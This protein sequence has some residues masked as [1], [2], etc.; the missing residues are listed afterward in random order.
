MNAL[1]RTKHSMPHSRL[2]I[3]NIATAGHGNEP[4]LH[5]DSGI[6]ILI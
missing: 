4:I 2:I 6:S 3:V 1:L 5:K